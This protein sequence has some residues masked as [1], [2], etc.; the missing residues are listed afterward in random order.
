MKPRGRQ[1]NIFQKH[2]ATLFTGRRQGLLSEMKTFVR[3]HRD[4]NTVIPTGNTIHMCG[5]VV[6][7]RGAQQHGRSAVYFC[8]MHLLFERPTTKAQKR[9]LQ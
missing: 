4:G 2:P 6:A 3:A 8:R 7:D 1:V 5:G 9:D